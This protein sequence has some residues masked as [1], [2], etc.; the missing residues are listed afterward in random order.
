MKW[1]K[2]LYIGDI[3]KDN[4]HSI[5]RKIKRYKPQLGVYV[6]TLPENENNILDIFP[7]IVL[8]QPYYKNKKLFI[9]GIASCK[10]E[11]Y[12]VMEKIVMDSYRL[13]GAFNIQEYIN[14]F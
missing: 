1:Y 3:A 13:T 9:I 5:I 11:A 14:N 2:N 4:K 7:S 10:E 12:E 6:L 8:L